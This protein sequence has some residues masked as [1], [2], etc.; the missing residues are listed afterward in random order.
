[1]SEDCLRGP[2]E[3]S[4]MPQFVC[5][6]CC[7]QFNGEDDAGSNATCPECGETYGHFFTPLIRCGTFALA[8][9]LDAEQREIRVHDKAA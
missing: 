4:V 6:K 8:Y 7:I 2:L 3:A 1:M 9:W 5:T